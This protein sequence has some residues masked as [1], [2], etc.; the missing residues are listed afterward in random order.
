[1]IMTSNYVEQALDATDADW[2]ATFTVNVQS[3]SSMGQAC[4]AEMKKIS[5][6]ENCSIVNF[7]SISAHQTQP[8][9]YLQIL[10]QH[11]YLI[12]FPDWI[13]D[14]IKVGS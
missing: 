14:N 13:P 4:Y 5:G 10:W 7:S 8:N 3:Y 1:M 6:K 12:L 9:R 11:V 2:T